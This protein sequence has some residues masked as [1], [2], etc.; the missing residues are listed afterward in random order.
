MGYRLQGK[1]IEFEEKSF[2][3]EGIALGAI[4]IPT[5]GQPMVLMRDRQ[6]IGGYTNPINFM[7]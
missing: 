1:P 6:T 5:N 2:V 4:Q 3:S 7:I